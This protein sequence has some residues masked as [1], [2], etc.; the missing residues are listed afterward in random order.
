MPWKESSVE[1]QR[2][3]FVEE[4]KR[5]E[6]NLAEL[7]RR[8]GVSRV[9]G[10]KWLERYEELGWKGLS[11]Q[12]RAPHHSP[13]AVNARRA[14]AIISLRGK[15][16]RWGPKKLKGVLERQRP[17]E[18]WPAAS[19]IG[20]L[21]KREGLVIG[22]RKR[23]K[24]PAGNQPLG[25]A[26]GPNVVWSADFKGWFRTRDGDRCNPLTI[27]D[28]HSRYLLRCQA[29][30]RGDTVH[31]QPV[32]EAVFREYGMPQAIRS[33][34]G[35]PFASHG[36]AGLSQ[37]S[38]WWVRL[39]IQVERIQPGHPEQNG[40]HERMHRTLKAETA[41]PPAPSR[42]G[43]Q[44]R[45][46]RFVQ[47]YNEIRPHEALGLQTP[48]SVY[49]PSPRRFPDRLPALEYAGDMVVRRVRQGGVMS[50]QGHNVFVGHA[51]DGE[52][53]ALR[54]LDDE[55]YQVYFGPV[56]LGS[57]QPGRRRVQHPPKPRKKIARQPSCGNDGP[58]ESG[59]NQTQV[60]P[61]SHSPLE[62]SQTPRDSHI[63]TA[64]TTAMV[65]PEPDRTEGK[66]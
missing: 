55:L 58:V 53:I 39:G 47:V 26:D 11:D 65:M 18:R 46:D 56:L 22:R 12:S 4:W 30:D 33:D 27:S 60:S 40:R 32:F 16:P 13:Q 38:V 24:A 5:G 43:Q 37:L 8:A 64:P 48:A 49:Q 29:L 59:E 20:E 1:E 19:T 54:Q 28:N 17:S 63:P 3:R 61:A 6:T 34:N 35:S 44:K 57:F 21:L 41:N 23:S 25:H 10:Y 51:L 7:C 31:V 52:W 62:I 50:W 2:F 36:I 66:V 14:A 42:R 15:Q 45:F 9:T